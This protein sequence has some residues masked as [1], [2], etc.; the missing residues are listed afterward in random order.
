[1]EMSMLQGNLGVQRTG[2]NNNNNHNNNNNN[3]NANNNNYNNNNRNSTNTAAYDADSTNEEEDEA[4]VD[5]AIGGDVTSSLLQRS[6]LNCRPSGPP[7]PYP[8]ATAAFASDQV[9]KTDSDIESTKSTQPL[10]SST[11][12][13]GTPPS[14]STARCSVAEDRDRFRLPMQSPAGESLPKVASAPETNAVAFAAGDKDSQKS[15]AVLPSWPMKR[16]APE[17]V[18]TPSLSDGP[19]SDRTTVAGSYSSVG[20]LLSRREGL[21]RQRTAD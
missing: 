19:C 12:A 1:M 17:D 2:N 15:G 13:E 14:S 4:D 6:D 8:A 20:G 5:Y 18:Q 21:A 7:P 10:I 9:E 11:K 3:N 16:S